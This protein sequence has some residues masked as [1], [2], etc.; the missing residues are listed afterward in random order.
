MIEAFSL[1]LGSALVAVADDGD[2]LAFEDG[3]V[4]VLIMVD[5]D[6]LLIP[7]ALSWAAGG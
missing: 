3:E 2:P 7:S 6:Q 5:L 4:G 1:S